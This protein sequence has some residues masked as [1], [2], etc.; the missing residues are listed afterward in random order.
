MK[1]WY[2]L[3]ANLIVTFKQFPMLVFAI[4]VTPVLLGLFLS[5]SSSSM[6]TPTVEP[7]KIPVY[8]DNLDKSAIGEHLDDSIAQLEK[9]D[10]VVREQDRQD[11]SVII[12]VPQDFGEELET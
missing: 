5:F 10:I 4:V 1:L 6:F 3:K 9:E 8:W 7:P 12:S 2:F 11:A